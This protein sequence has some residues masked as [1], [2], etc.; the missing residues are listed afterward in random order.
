MRPHLRHPRLGHLLSNT[1]TKFHPRNATVAPQ[2]VLPG[3]PEGNALSKDERRLLVANR[4]DVMLVEML[5][6][7]AITVQV[8]PNSAL[9]NDNAALSATRDGT[10]DIAMSRDRP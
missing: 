2:A 1:V 10:I 8:Y 3:W 9:G 4:G 5:S 6:V 7:F